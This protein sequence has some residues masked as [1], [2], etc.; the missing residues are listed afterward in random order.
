[1]TENTE[2]NL[3]DLIDTTFGLE[4]TDALER[5]LLCDT[6]DDAQAMIDAACAPSYQ[7]AFVMLWCVARGAAIALE[8][9]CPAPR[10]RAQHEM[11][12]AP[13]EDIDRWP[14]EQR[15][16]IRFA[17]ACIRFDRPA[18]VELFTAFTAVAPGALPGA[19]RALFHF[20]IHQLHG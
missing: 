20:L 15:F 4:L 19:Q 6:A 2:A 1:M 14:A 7:H 8:D 13:G 3:A 9:N 16:A 12:L 18:A 5:A 17:N 10:C 11:A